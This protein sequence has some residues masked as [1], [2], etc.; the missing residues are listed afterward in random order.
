MRVLVEGLVQEEDQEGEQDEEH[1]VLGA[2]LRLL[3]A[4]HRQEQVHPETERLPILLPD[5]SPSRQA[6]GKL[7]ERCKVVQSAWKPAAFTERLSG[8]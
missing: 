3:V 5:I 4:V 2:A 7:R 1:R 6:W 8:R